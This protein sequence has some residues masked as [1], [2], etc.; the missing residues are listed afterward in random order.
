MEPFFDVKTV[1]TIFHLFGVVFGAGGAAASDI[2]FFSSVKDHKIT[3]TE[4]R[5]LHLGSMMTWFGLALLALSGLGLFM[6]NPEGYMQSSKFIAKMIIVAI[7]T[8]NGAIFHYDH[9]PWLHKHVDM[10][11][12]SADQFTRK[13][14]FLIISGAVSVT[15]WLA[16]LILGSLRMIPFTVPQAL[17][18]YAV[19]L[20]IAVSIGLTFQNHIFCI[21]DCACKTGNCSHKPKT[22]RKR[23]NT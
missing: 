18:G 22:R 13:A 5:F 7:I 4:A 1:L 15:G 8:L 20:L 12:V 14:P 21:P 9:I 11:L 23:K 16:A 6:T 3:K 2:M 17:G 19:F 10:P